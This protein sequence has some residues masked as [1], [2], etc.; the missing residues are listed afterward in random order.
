MQSGKRDRGEWFGRWA[1][2]W[3][4]LTIRP[5]GFRIRIGMASAVLMPQSALDPGQRATGTASRPE[6]GRRAARGRAED[7]FE[8]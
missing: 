7:G 1:Q 8:V 6:A 5:P 2:K 4:G 3:A